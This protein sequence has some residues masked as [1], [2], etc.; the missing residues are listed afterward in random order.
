MRALLIDPGTES[1]HEIDTAGEL[2]DMY[3][4]IGCS[5]INMVRISADDLVWVDGEGL[6]K[7]DQEFFA[8]TSYYQPLAGRGLVLGIGNEGENTAAKI[9]LAELSA[10]VTWPD[11]EFDGVTVHNDEITHPSFGKMARHTQT[12]HFKDKEHEPRS[13]SPD[14]EDQDGDVH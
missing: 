12:A 10:M 6:F 5:D 4:L 3:K 14:S 11:V 2:E 1:I 13:T 8:V 7:E 9:S